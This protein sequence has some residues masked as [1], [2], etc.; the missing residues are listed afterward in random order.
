M[1]A[2]KS[3]LAVV[4]LVTIAAAAFVLDIA[5]LRGMTSLQMNDFG[6]FYYSARAFLD[7]GNMYATSPATDLKFA[8]APGLQ[9]LN[10]NPPHFHLIVLPL[11][12][13]SPQPALTIWVGASLLALVLSILLIVREVG[14][15]WTPNRVLAAATGTLLFTA[16]QSFF[17]TGQL[18][19]LLLLALT[20][21]WVE[22][23]HDR[24]TTAAAVLGACLSV[25]PFLLIFAPYLLLT[26]RFRAAVVMLATAAA[27]VAI[28]VLVFGFTQYEAWYRA[29]RQSGDWS[30]AVMNA[31]MLGLFR[32]AFDTQPIGTPLV[33][34][35]SLVNG[36]I[37]AA[38]LVGTV[39][40]VVTIRDREPHAIDRS[41]ALLLVAAQLISPLGW[42]YYLWLPAGPIAALATPH[43]ASGFRRTSA[44]AG[45]PKG[46]RHVLK[47]VLA[48]VA[49]IG[50]VYPM[51]F[52]LAFR[53][54]AWATLTIAS[55][56]FWATLALWLLLLDDGRR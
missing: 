54:H 3:V 2:V 15:A 52:L 11:A 44:T 43:V 37:V 4:A 29:L 32:R 39:T 47:R 34:A 17:A 48:L 55:I 30:W 6:K 10:M 51:P 23:R 36:W 49:M 27:L 25:K 24:W 21:C 16:T 35:P 1:P 22:A 38:A 50:F 20:I 5:L 19:L 8:E 7:G 56:Y 41:F 12:L 42:I 45:S 18:S 14:L 31:S 28:G 26:R 13:L 53:N 46:R 33:V 40:L 9:F